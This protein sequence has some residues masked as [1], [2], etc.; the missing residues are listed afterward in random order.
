MNRRSFLGLTFFSATAGAV[1]AVT[2]GASQAR[3]ENPIAPIRRRVISY[4]A[5]SYYH[6]YIV[7]YSCALGG[8][9]YCFAE[10]V[11]DRGVTDVLNYDQQAINAFKR[12]ADKLGV[13]APTTII[14]G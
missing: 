13:P 12:R 5:H 7:Q 1:A 10:R 6:E 3:A 2:A 8:S 11:L 4:S 9:E 14:N